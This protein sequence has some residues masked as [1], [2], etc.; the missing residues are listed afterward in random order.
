M[1][2]K[3]FYFD[4]ARTWSL[5][6][7][8][9]GSVLKLCWKVVVGIGGSPGERRCERRPRLGRRRRASRAGNVS[10]QIAASSPDR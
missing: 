1:L 8:A 9:D 5:I 3:C 7:T 10:E 4:A 6:Y 2:E